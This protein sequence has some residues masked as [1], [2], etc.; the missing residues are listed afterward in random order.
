MENE[1]LKKPKGKSDVGNLDKKVRT[2]GLTG[3][4]LHMVLALQNSNQLYAGR[5]Q[6]G[7]PRKP[8]S[9]TSKQGIEQTSSPPKSHL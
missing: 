8:V 6:E 5:R 9:T 7:L 2:K 1:V 3:S 4:W